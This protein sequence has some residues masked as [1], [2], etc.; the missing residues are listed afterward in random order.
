MRIM[1][2]L[3]GLCSLLAGCGV[4][5]RVDARNEYQASVAN[6]KACLASN[7]PQSCESRRLAMEVDERKF[8]N[9]NAAASDGTLTVINR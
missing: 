5:A 6:Y 4:V 2:A 9:L 8:N 7:P 1:L 3:I